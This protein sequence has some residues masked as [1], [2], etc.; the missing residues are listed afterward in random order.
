MNPLFVTEDKEAVAKD[1]K[2]YT[3]IFTELPITEHQ[4]SL[5]K[6]GVKD[7]KRCAVIVTPEE[8][9]QL[10]QAVIQNCQ[11]FI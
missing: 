1:L 11:T 9:Q 6:N 10:P 2:Q 5:I 7:G 4:I 8:A 3:D